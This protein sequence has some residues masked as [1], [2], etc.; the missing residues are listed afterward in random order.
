MKIDIIKS[1]AHASMKTVKGYEM[2]ATSSL[3]KSTLSLEV[4]RSFNRAV[5]S[6]FPFFEI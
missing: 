4:E 2:L 1:A 6:L 5:T 3:E